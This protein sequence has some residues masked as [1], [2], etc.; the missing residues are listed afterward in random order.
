MVTIV[1]AIMKIV[2]ILV[3]TMKMAENGNDNGS[4]L[5]C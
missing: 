2:P 1:V 3:A 4:Y 5:V